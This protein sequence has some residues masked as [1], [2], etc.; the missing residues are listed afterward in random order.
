[1]SDGTGHWPWMVLDVAVQF[2]FEMP[3][4]HVGLFG[5][6]VGRWRVHELNE[7]GSI[8]GP[9]KLKYYWMYKGINHQAKTLEEIV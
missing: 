4:F 7:D 3:A 6:T 1:M 2:G 9:D 5:F 8:K